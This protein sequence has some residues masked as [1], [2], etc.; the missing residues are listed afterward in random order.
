[1]D[2]K[3][4]KINA[5]T[6][7][8]VE[9]SFTRFNQ[10]NNIMIRVM[11]DDEI[12]SLDNL[13]KENIIKYIKEGRPGYSH[14]DYAFGKGALRFIEEI[15]YSINICDQ[16]AN[17]WTNSDAQYLGK[18]QGDKNELT[19]AIIKAGK[20][21]GASA[22]GIAPLD[23]RWVFS[24]WFDPKT[25]ESYP[26]VFSDEEEGLGHIKEPMVVEGLKRV[27]PAS[28][29][30]VIVFLFEMDYETL[31][32]AP[33]ILPYANSIDVY[34]KMTFATKSMAELIRNLGYAAIPS[35]NCTALNIPLAIDGGLG[36]LGRNGKLI[37]P[38]LGPK[39]RIAKVITDLPLV[40]SQPIDFGVNEFCD[41][42]RQCV[43]KCPVGAIS[44]GPGIN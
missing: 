34:A 13:R 32:Y 43:K 1:M 4:E 16:G 31:Q 7:Y 8:Q 29:A 41:V 5:A 28:M 25:K 35:I 30:T 18:W 40:Y 21:Y 24:H 2:G 33:T 19:S 15:D 10:K 6:S 27:I 11:W 39:C 23:R 12:K 3:A 36:Q 37:H 20:I 17:S 26:M 9:E 22:V 44:N 38:Q 42:C 14:F